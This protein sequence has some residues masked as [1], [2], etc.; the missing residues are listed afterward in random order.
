M[1]QCYT[2]YNIVPY[3]FLSWA[4]QCRFVMILRSVGG[5]P[6]LCNSLKINIIKSTATDKNL[7]VNELLHTILELHLTTI[8]IMQIT[9]PGKFQGPK[10]YQSCLGFYTY[11]VYS[12]PTAWEG[13]SQDLVGKIGISG[14]NFSKMR[15]LTNG[16]V[17]I[18][19]YL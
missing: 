6:I 19:I 8:P 9:I 3:F 5:Q 16:S 10:P 18:K 2:I 4:V 1:G 11:R 17:N 12:I 7:K 13:S 14:K 15:S